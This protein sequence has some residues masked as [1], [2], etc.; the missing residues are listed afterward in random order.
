MKK[1]KIMKD[2]EKKYD[3]LFVRW[4]KNKY[5]SS[6]ECENGLLIDLDKKGNV[7]GFELDG[8]KQFCSHKTSKE[9]IHQAKKDETS[10]DSHLGT[11]SKSEEDIKL[12]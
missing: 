4:S 8:V 5:H 1:I 10:N 6:V 2:Y 7:I 11:R 3:L 12:V 9:N